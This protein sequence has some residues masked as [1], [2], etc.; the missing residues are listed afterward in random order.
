MNI[1]ITGANGFLG[2]KITRKIIA[3]TEFDVTAVASSEKKVQEMCEREDVERE[4]VHF[5]SNEDFLKP[6]TELKNTYGAVHLAFARR[7]RPASEIASSLD[8]AAAV[9]HKLANSDIERV[10][11]MSSQGVYGNTDE[12]RTE[13]T[14]P[15]PETQYTMA[16]YAAEILFRDI[17][18]DCPLHTSFRLDP[19]TQTQKVIKSLC[20]SA[21]DGKIYLKGG[22]QVFS[23]VDGGDAA[24]AVVAMLKAEGEWESVYNVGLDQRRYT[25]VELAELVAD[26]AECNGFNRPIISLEE[27]DVELWAG[28][29]SSR[30]MIKTGW[31]PET[32]LKETLRKLLVKG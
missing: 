24:S 17:L 9:F 7:M 1:L 11:N 21:K 15:A 3:N 20:E 16:K 32:H 22:K 30:F 14:P 2:G 27:S 19:V 13:S 29:D 8:Y 6:E 12:I 4:R 18:R 25:L 23:F 10:I 5:L 26:A 28:M 31:K